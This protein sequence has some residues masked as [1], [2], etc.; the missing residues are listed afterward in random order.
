MS[1]A[2]GSGII[3]KEQ[4]VEQICW[5]IR[6][7]VGNTGLVVSS[8]DLTSVSEDHAWSLKDFQLGAP[9]AKGCAAV[10]YSARCSNDISCDNVSIEKF[11]LAI[12]MM[13]NFD[14]ESN[15]TSIL[16]AMQRETVPARSISLAGS[17]VGVEEVIHLASHPNIVQMVAVF[18]DQVS[19]HQLDPADNSLFPGSPPTRRH[20]YVRPR[21]PLK[22]QSLRLWP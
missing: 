18:A 15:A 19:I 2:S 12:K 17:A 6:R 16:R 21:P 13:F 8:R 1:L 5:E 9:I 4:E 10:I 20:L 22:D 7:A 3:S 11:P 14:A